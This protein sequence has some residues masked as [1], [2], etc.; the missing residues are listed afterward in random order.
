[1]GEEELNK[2]IENMVKVMH[3]SNAKEIYSK[4]A[5]IATTLLE[6]SLFYDMNYQ[7]IVEKFREIYDELRKKGGL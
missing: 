7:E 1:M 5:D 6:M 4:T 3:V 2:Q